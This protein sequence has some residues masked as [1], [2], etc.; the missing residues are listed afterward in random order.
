VEICRIKDNLARHKNDLHAMLLESVDY[1]ETSDLGNN[2]ILESGI[3]NRS[4]PGATTGS[5]KSSSA[6]SNRST[7]KSFGFTDVFQKSIFYPFLVILVLMFLLQFS[8]QG[9]VTF[10]TALIFEEA[11]SSVD[12]NDCALVI[13]VTYFLSSILGNQLN[14]R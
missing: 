11:E 12:P 8:G 14:C 2:S 5:R 4:L 10:Y 6:I 1:M 13:G 9:A 3:D 7:Y